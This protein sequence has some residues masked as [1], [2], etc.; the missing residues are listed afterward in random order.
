MSFIHTAPN[1]VMPGQKREARVFA[2]LPGHDGKTNRHRLE[3]Q[4][5]MRA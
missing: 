1:F 3:G 4:L 2:L 5:Q